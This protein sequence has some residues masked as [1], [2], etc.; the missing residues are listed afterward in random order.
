MVKDISE[1]DVF[2]E[3][4]FI[5]KANH[6]H[7]FHAGENKFIPD[8]LGGSNDCLAIKFAAPVLFLE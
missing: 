8:A 1:G 5:F 6:P 3:G 7:F 4:G 2:E